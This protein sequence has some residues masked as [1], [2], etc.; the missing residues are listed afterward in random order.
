MNFQSV[1]GFKDV[2][3]ADAER[4]TALEAAARTI[5]ARFGMR[6]LRLPTLESRELFVKS[7]GE[8]T[9]IVEKEMFLLEDAG[10]R[11]LA[12]RPEGTPGAVR[13]YLQHRL[14]QQGGRTKLYYIGSMFRAERPQAGRYR[15][16]EQIGAEYFGNPHPAADAEMLLSLS[17]ILD[18]AGANGSYSV[19][20]NNLGCESQECRPDFRK[21]LLEFLE[22][23]RRELCEH[24][25][26]RMARNPLRVLDCK[27]DSP[28]L[29]SSP[30]MPVLSPCGECR[31]HFD[32][33]GRLLS[34]ARL[35]WS[36]DPSLVRGLDYYTRVVFEFK[37][38]A[39]GAQD[40]IAGG[41]RYDG[42]V[43]S[44]GG[45]EVPAVGWALGVERVLLA[46]AA[47]A[48]PDS[49]AP[50]YVAI[51]EDCEM[52]DSMRAILEDSAFD[53]LHRLRSRGVA[54]EAGFGHSLKAQ[55]REA[56]RLG[57]EHVVIFGAR[58]HREGRCVLKDMKA[59][60]RQ[61]T[62]PVEQ[63]LDRLLRQVRP[64]DDA[65]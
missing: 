54:S 26:G 47:P 15:E 8:T 64:K 53:L 28:R 57:A 33:L 4:C 62:I 14:A 44:M 22:S 27:A 38:P 46:A 9:D 35:E 21:R 23:V 39:L 45:P 6:E 41:G 17:E 50:V 5:L 3:P 60:D 7:T 36:Q 2:L 37:S 24:C 55:M 51:Q 59:K 32:A 49:R 63:V 58:E 12:L 34:R 25:R 10:G 52:E 42:L 29:R 11:R 48:R 61:S 65:P 19:H 13:A 43:R 18:A 30:G 20:I 31:R 56:D 1:R 16:F 40:A